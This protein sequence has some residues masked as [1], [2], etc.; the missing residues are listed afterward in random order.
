M[1]NFNKPVHIWVVIIIL[2]TFTFLIGGF[3]VWQFNLFKKEIEL[4]EVKLITP[5]TQKKI[6]SSSDEIIEREIIHPLILKMNEIGDERLIV[7]K[8]LCDEC[9]KNGKECKSCFEKVASY[10]EIKEDLNRDGKEEIVV[11]LGSL[12]VEEPS[13]I[14]L[15]NTGEGYKI[16]DQV[17]TGLNIKSMEL[18]KIPNEHYWS[19]IVNTGGGM[20]TGLH[21]EE[22]LVYTYLNN[23][24]K[25]TWKGYTLFE[26]VNPSNIE[27]KVYHIKFVDIDNDDNFEINQRG[28]ER[29]KEAKWDEE[30]GEFSPP[31]EV[32]RSVDKYFKWNPKSEQFEEILEK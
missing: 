26:E 30:K 19:I 12:D 16:V 25:L 13:I 31:I 27:E 20:G 7:N 10:F 3:L 1:N 15:S 14:L 17:K 2:L 9:I 28:L 11:G 21:G 18:K 24:L 6:I 22:M 4:E 23:K 5:T 32:M 8:S 29:K